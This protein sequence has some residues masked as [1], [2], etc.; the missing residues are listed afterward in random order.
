MHFTMIQNKKQ[1]KIIIQQAYVTTYHGVLYVLYI[2]KLHRSDQM[3]MTECVAYSK[4]Q[5]HTS[6]SGGVY[7]DVAYM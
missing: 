4:T 3:K 2:C 1:S 7:D 6:G 5:T